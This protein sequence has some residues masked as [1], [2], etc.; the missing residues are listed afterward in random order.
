MISKIT[1]VDQSRLSMSY[2]QRIVIAF[3]LMMFVFLILTI[4]MVYLQLFEYEHY[5]KLS[6]DNRID[7]VSLAPT[8]GLILDRNGILIADNKPEYGLAIVPEE[9]DNIRNLIAKL[10]QYTN[11]SES[12][13]KS[14]FKRLGW[15]RRFESILLKTSIP[16]DDLAKIS[17]DLHMLKGVELSANLNR[18][19]PKG[20]S[21][22][23]VL[24][25][26]GI[27][28]QQET[29]K[30]NTSNYAASR[31]IGKQGVEKVLE[32]LLHGQVGF[33][34]VEVDVHSRPVRTIQ[35][36]LP[37]PG[38]SIHLSMDARLQ[39]F[40]YDV[41][42]PKR[43]AIVA[44]QPES[45]DILAMASWPAFDNNLFAKGISHADYKTLTNNKDRPLFHR[46]ISG[47]Y[48]P[49]STIK[50]FLGLLNLKEKAIPKHVHIYDPGF[51][52]INGRGRRFRDWKRTG[53]GRVDLHRS[54]V[55]SCDTYFYRMAEKIGID[56]MHDFL[57][58]IGFNHSLLDGWKAEANGLIPSKAWKKRTK[59]KPWYRGETLNSGIGQGYTLTTPLQLAFA[60]AWTASR[61]QLAQIAIH[62]GSN[63]P[64]PTYQGDFSATDWKLI[65]NSMRDVVHGGEGT[66]RK[67]S[68]GI[69]YQMA[70]KTGTAQ[71]FSLHPGFVYNSAEIDER[72]RDH[73]LFIAFA[74][75]DKPKIAVATIIENGD[76]GSAVMPTREVIDYYLHS[77]Q[78]HGLAQ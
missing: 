44:I 18:Y 38:K 8:R 20:E 33:K 68:R 64:I 41:L 65:H 76:S 22:S 60:T 39:Y 48:P 53:H 10:K 24:G 34:Q 73:G 49:G 16:S 28:D 11:I 50:P 4:R 9:V 61:G 75:L 58:K 46:A 66:A 62:Q 13:E 37:I 27:I 12:E 19:Y 1:P 71:V 15:K 6:N 31:F 67:A 14:F 52:Q 29:K 78:H 77:L 17:I 57:S 55:V 32:P 43:G 7:L 36:S 23:H 63:R 74:P 26:T 35:E 5:K 59:G 70:G 3:S 2:Q 45:G 56:T 30:I 69:Q 72:L 25:F 51:Y 40:A 42:K 47:Q 54:I 21:F